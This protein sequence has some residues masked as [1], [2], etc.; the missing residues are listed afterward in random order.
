MQSLRGK[1]I[2]LA[3]DEKG[4]QNAISLLLRQ[5]EYHVT[6]TDNCRDCLKSIFSNFRAATPIDLLICDLGSSMNDCDN[7]LQALD[8]VRISLPIIVLTEY[9]VEGCTDCHSLTSN[10]LFINKPF[11]PHSLMLGVEEILGNSVFR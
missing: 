2:L 11:E 4:L 8:K 7:L 3:E 5:A 6:L 1:H 9:G 10:V